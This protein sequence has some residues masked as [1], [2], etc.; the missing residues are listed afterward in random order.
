MAASCASALMHMAHCHEVFLS[1]KQR[2]I[3]GVDDR[4]VMDEIPSCDPLIIDASCGAAGCWTATHQRRRF[5]I[6]T[7]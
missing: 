1:N 2:R 5:A 3:P 7:R 4:P 6:A